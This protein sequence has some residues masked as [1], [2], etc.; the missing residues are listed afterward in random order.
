M[1]RPL[2]LAFSGA[3]NVRARGNAREAVFADDTDREAFLEGLVGACG[4]FDWA[5]WACCLVGNHYHLLI[6]TQCASLSRG[7]GEVN[8]VHTQRFNR[9]HRPVGHVLQGRCKAVLVDRDSYLLEVSHYLVLDPSRE[10]AG[11]WRLLAQ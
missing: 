10:A 4:R 11:A 1:S 2:R 5:L 7:M 3:L 6:E 9:R 8:G